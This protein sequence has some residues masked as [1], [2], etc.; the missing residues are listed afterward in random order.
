MGYYDNSV[1]SLLNFSRQHSITN[2]KKQLLSYPCY[3][4]RE[5]ITECM[6]T[7]YDLGEHVASWVSLPHF[8]Q[9]DNTFPVPVCKQIPVTKR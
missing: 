1:D 3:F 7:C 9:G 2:W 4:W 6:H 8:A 5:G